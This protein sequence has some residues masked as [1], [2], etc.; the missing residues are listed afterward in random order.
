MAGQVAQAIAVVAAHVVENV[1]QPPIVG[2]RFEHGRRM[3]AES[4]VEQPGLLFRRQLQRVGHRRNAQQ[5]V[6]PLAAGKLF[7]VVGNL[8]EQHGH[9]IDRAANV[10]VMLEVRR[11]VGVILDGVQENP[12][13]QE[14]AGFRMAIIRLV[15]VPEKG[16]I[17]HQRPAAAPC[18]SISAVTRVMP[19]G[20]T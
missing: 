9:E 14:L 20:L 18:P 2:E 11:H 7:G 4:H 15:H 17:S 3:A 6:A 5:G 12:G 10:R 13:Q 16:E 19:F 8:V 1:A